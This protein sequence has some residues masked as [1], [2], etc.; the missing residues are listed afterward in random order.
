MQDARKGPRMDEDAVAPRHGV[1]GGPV[2]YQHGMRGE[3][4]GLAQ[5]QDV[6]NGKG[7]SRGGKCRE[8]GEIGLQVPSHRPVGLG[9]QPPW[10]GEPWA[11]HGEPCDRKSGNALGPVT[12]VRCP[13]G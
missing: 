3:I 12:A 4:W 13:Q 8:I 10:S 2:R 6:A 11:N 9:N 5:G 7:T 1:S